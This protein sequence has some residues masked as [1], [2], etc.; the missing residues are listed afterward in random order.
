MNATTE[1]DPVLRWAARRDAIN[2]ANAQHSTVPRTAPGKQ[3]SSLNAITHGLSATTAVLPTEDQTDYEKHCRQF[4]DEYQPATA[5]ETQLVQEIADTA[6]R[7]EADL[8]ARAA[9]PP[10][11]QAAIAF[12][13]VD[14]HRL[15]TNLGLHST[16]LS[17]QFNKAVDHLH[18][19]QAERRERER[20]QLKDAAQLLDLYKRRELP[21][22]PSDH[23]FV[24]SLDQVERHREYLIRTNEAHHA[25][26]SRF[27]APPALMRSFVATPIT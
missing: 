26:Y 7:L 15:L 21:W 8:L 9:N 6:W 3:R 24:F 25:A 22:Q 20:R 4:R 1:T 16:R 19:L 12:D 17:R 23:G 5:T 27:E 14:A 10:N 18:A 13:I 11:P 2:R